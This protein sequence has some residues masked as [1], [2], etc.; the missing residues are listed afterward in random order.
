MVLKIGQE[1]A[2]DRAKLLTSKGKSGLAHSGQARVARCPPSL[3]SGE[4]FRVIDCPTG[5]ANCVG[6]V[7]RTRRAVSA[8]RKLGTRSVGLSPWCPYRSAGEESRF[9]DSARQLSRKQFTGSILPGPRQVPGRWSF[10][11]VNP[12]MVWVTPHDLNS[13]LEFEDWREAKVY[14]KCNLWKEM[15]YSRVVLKINKTKQAYSL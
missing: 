3:P 14:S 12:V 1:N 2:K 8:I 13:H 11:T 6:R 4:P 15:N 7:G 5:W 9:A 10:C